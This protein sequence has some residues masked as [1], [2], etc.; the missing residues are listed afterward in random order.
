MAPSTIVQIGCGIVGHAYALAF[1][2]AGHRVIGVEA[3]YNRM[4]QISHCYDVHHV[5]DDLSILHN[6]HFILLSI[7]T[8]LDP[9]AGALNMS[10]IWGSL[11]NVTAIIRSNPNALVVVRSTVTIGFCSAYKAAVEKEVGH[12][13]RL[14]FQP[15]FLR[16][17]SAV[18]DATSPWQVV[19]GCDSAHDISDYYRFQQQF[20][21]ADNITFCTIDEAEI[22]KIFHNSFNAMK[23]S[24]FNQAD[25]LVQEIRRRDDKKIDA[26]RTFKIIARTCEGLINPTYGLTPGH[27]YYGTCL[28][29]DSAE[30]A[31]MERLYALQCNLFQSVVHVN[32]AV[33]ATDTEEV[34][35]GDNHADNAAFHKA[36]H[37][38][39]ARPAA[40]P[41]DGSSCSSG[42]VSEEESECVSAQ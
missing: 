4:N 29:K 18:E 12:S 41:T 26:E 34:L 10:Y 31:N 2:N 6:V 25:L 39:V 37:A 14:C 27:A 35:Y 21:A 19:L 16:A 9:H 33:K 13:V 24:Y 11:A 42:S 20:I 32:N 30:L 7:N 36:V 15:E 3:S 23:I 5:S 8:P 28:P 1:S 40:M 22:M 38:K 17:R